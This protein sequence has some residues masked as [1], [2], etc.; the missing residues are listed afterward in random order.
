MRQGPGQQCVKCWG[1]LKS[2]KWNFD[3]A[4]E[5]LKSFENRDLGQAIARWGD[6]L[7][8]MAG[9]LRSLFVAALGHRFVCSDYRAIEAVVL[10]A[11][12]GEEWRLE[13]FRTHGK[14]YEQSASKITGTPLEDYLAYKE[15]HGEHHPDRQAIGKVAELA[16]GY[17]GGLG[18]WKAFGADK[19]MTED[20]I[21]ANVK[22]WRRESPNIVNFWY[23]LE[24]AAI[25]AI[26]SPGHAYR[27]RDIHYWSDGKVLR[28]VLP[29]GR[30]LVYHK[31][32]V[33]DGVTPWGSPA[34]RIRFWGWNS[35]P[36]YGPI[37][38]HELETYGGRL[39]ENVVQA[40]SRDIMA[41]GM[42]HADRA[43]YNI[44]LHNHDEIVS[45]QLNGHGS[46]AELEGLMG[47]L[48]PWAAGWPVIAHGGWEGKFYR[49]D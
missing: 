31:P 30:S 6:V 39:T 15:E 18:A 49:K 33:E 16:S 14:I 43:G 44:V 47:R 4:L 11:L 34:K 3:T 29:S 8:V 22:R 9:T 26:G 13:V 7:D 24:R 25:N 21:K 12:A 42:L 23:G 2:T 27:Y 32:R 17:G 46:V 48:P 1:P 20:E 40:A 35:N 45:E 41:H 36:K 5:A 37:G 10:A 28:C 38:W 19:H